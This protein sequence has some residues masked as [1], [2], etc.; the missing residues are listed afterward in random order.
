M[1]PMAK[2]CPHVGALLLVH[3]DEPALVDLHA[4]GLGADHLPV[5]LAPDRDQD[6]VEH[7][8]LGGL[9]ALEVNGQPI[10][11]GLHVGDLGLHPD[12]L[13]ALGQPPGKR[14][15]QV[16]VRAGDELVQQLHH[17]HLRAQLVVDG[18]HLQADDPAAQDEQPLRDP[19]QLQRAGGVDHAGIVVWDERQRDRLGAGGDDGL[20]E[21]DRAGRPVVGGDLDHVR[22][23]ELAGADHGGD[24]ALFGQPGQPTGEPVDHALFPATQRAQVDGRRGE[25]QSVAGHLLGLGD[26]LGRVQQRLGRDAAH[27][28]AHPAERAAAVDH[29]NLLAEVGGPERCG[30]AARPG[31][32]HQHLGVLIAAFDVR[33]GR[34]RRRSR[35]H[36]L[37][38]CGLGDLLG[39]CRG[40]SCWGGVAALGVDHHDHAACGHGVAHGDPQLGHRPGY[41]GWYIECGLVRF[42]RDQRVLGRDGVARRDVDLDHRDVRE[43]ADVGDLDL[44]RA[45]RVAPWWSKWSAAK[46]VTAAAVGRLRAGSTGVGRSGRPVHRR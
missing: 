2:T 9:A 19:I 29:H 14:F 6:L 16:R 1:S 4:R 17:A 23:G 35:G 42:Q 33:G 20:F 34:R 3:R 31:A 11:S 37:R 18:R 13:V 22:R 5:G 30:V 46:A 32:E 21:A 25:G 7:R 10:L 44:L 15:D 26:H 43:V 39:R 40:R 45:H 12:V 24:L 41:R 28:Q 38:G 8:R 36:R 27:I